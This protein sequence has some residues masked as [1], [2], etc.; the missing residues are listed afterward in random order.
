[1]TDENKELGRFI[2]KYA[3]IMCNFRTAPKVFRD[4]ILPI[5]TM[6][7]EYDE[8]IQQSGEKP[9]TDEKWI[10]KMSER[11]YLDGINYKFRKY[12]SCEDFIRQI[13]AEV[14]NKKG[15]INGS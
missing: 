1:M 12:Q 10:K 11:L 15:E 6:L 14:L 13:V 3:E 9:E 2:K 8:R 5:K 7:K 4:Y